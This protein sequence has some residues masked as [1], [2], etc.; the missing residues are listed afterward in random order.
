MSGQAL[1]DA[2]A[3]PWLMPRTI[4]A[5]TAWNRVVLV[6]ALLWVVLGI[7]CFGFGAQLIADRYGRTVE[8]AFRLDLV[9]LVGLGLI[10]TA[11]VG[12]QRHHG[13]TI[14]DLGWAAPTPRRAV[15][16][17]V[18]YGLLWTALSYARGGNPLAWTWQRPVMV[19]IGLVLVFGEELARGFMMEQLRRGGIASWSQVVV[20]GLILGSYH[21]VLGHSFNVVYALTSAVLFGLLSVAVRNQSAQPPTL[22]HR[23]RDDAF[24]GRPHFDPRHPHRCYQHI[25]RLGFRGLRSLRK[26]ESSQGAKFSCM[27]QPRRFAASA[28]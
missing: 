1:D 27:S 13:E 11:V 25:N 18:I 7:G 10:I 16:I 9:F 3:I 2:E 23:S 26:L 6:T 14:L 12:W 28:A 20:S 24:P 8:A 15:A 21:G 19:V 4:P 5:R 17:G 22:L